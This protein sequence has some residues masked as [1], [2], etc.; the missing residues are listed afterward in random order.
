MNKLTRQ[1]NEQLDLDKRI[2]VGFIEIFTK[3]M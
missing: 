1:F 3:Q 2:F